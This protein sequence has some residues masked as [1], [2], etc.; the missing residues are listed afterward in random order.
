[1]A[2]RKLCLRHA[3]H[4]NNHWKMIVPKFQTLLISEI[5][6][7][8]S[9]FWIVSSLFVYFLKE[10]ATNQRL[11]TTPKT[12]AA[13]ISGRLVTLEAKVSSL[14][15]KAHRYSQ[16]GNT[17]AARYGEDV[18]RMFG[19][20]CSSERILLYKLITFSAYKK[21]NL[22]PFDSFS[23]WFSTTSLFSFTNF[24]HTFTTVS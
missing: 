18:C 19:I 2:N 10:F 15:P 7:H 11:S 9:H 24:G 17:W 5:T 6:A 12:S 23:S 3:A 14:A 13:T 1:M 16:Y 8:F 20:P 22:R 21:K 4:C